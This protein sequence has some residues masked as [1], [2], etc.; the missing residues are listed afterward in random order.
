MDRKKTLEEAIR[1]TTTERNDA[2]GE[3]EDSFAC[4][5]EFWAVYD[6][7]K[8][9][10]M[11]EGHDAAIKMALLKIARIATG[12]GIKDDNYID[13]AGYISLASEIEE[14][15]RLKERIKAQSGGPI[16]IPTDFRVFQ[17]GSKL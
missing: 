8:S 1:V 15:Y 5:G 7:H 12:G 2:Y 6:K 4:I 17:L 3:P 9:G 16:V 13:G 11:S 14:K 10:K